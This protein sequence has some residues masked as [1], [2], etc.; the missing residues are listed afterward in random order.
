MA[1]GCINKANAGMMGPPC[2]HHISPRLHPGWGGAVA[3]AKKQPDD[4]GEEKLCR[5]KAIGHFKGL[6]LPWE[7]K[8]PEGRDFVLFAVCVISGAVS[9][10]GAQ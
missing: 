5:K 1:P 8:F 3:I 6:R 10:I 4:K 7:T 2:S 9:E